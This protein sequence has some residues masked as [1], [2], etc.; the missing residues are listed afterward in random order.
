VP[1]T[2]AHVAPLSGGGLLFTNQAGQALRGSG[3]GVRPLRLPPLPP[4]TAAIEAADGAIVA[5]T[6]RGP[7]RLPPP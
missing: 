3:E 7:R 1:V 6:Y 5:A 4:L 2:L